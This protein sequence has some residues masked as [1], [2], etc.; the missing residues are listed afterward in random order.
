MVGRFPVL[1]IA[2]ADAED[3]VMSS[4]VL[5]Y[6]ADSLPNATFTQAY[7]MT[8]LAPVAT[9]LSAEDHDLPGLGRSCGRPASHAEVRIV[10]P[11]DLPLPPG[12]VGEIVSR[13]DH[14][15]QGYWNK[16]QETAAALRG[17]WMHTG[18]AGYMNED[19]YFF[20]V[21]RIRT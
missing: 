6:L 1:Y 9:L 8:E 14:M 10:G 19:G 3:A 17:G 5:A 20:V 12:E 21:D 4:G 2:E 18:D 7:G 16:P 11:D 13:G 15:M